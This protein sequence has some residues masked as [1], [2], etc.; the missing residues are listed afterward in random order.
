MIG[1]GSGMVRA[2]LE[3]DG[4]VTEMLPDGAQRTV[5]PKPDWA[6]VDA[7]TDAEIACHIAEDAAEAAQ[8]SAAWV[9]RVR[10][11][12]GLS[13]KAFAKQIGVTVA[14]LRDWEHG[15]RAPHGPA[16]A[17]LRVIERE[18]EAVLRALSG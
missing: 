5:S 14:T 18:P 9:V 16:R 2:T 13:R 10:G 3:P 12:L 15:K 7:T 4:T 17:F 8:D 6:R 11:R 1:K